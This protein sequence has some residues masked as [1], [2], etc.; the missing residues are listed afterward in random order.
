MDTLNETNSDQVNEI[1]DGNTV[2][3]S[4]SLFLTRAI[5]QYASAG[6][7]AENLSF[8]ATDTIASH[9][10]TT[11]SVIH[12]DAIDE[13]PPLLIKTLDPSIDSFSIHWLNLSAF[14]VPLFGGPDFNRRNSSL[15]GS[16]C[17]TFDLSKLGGPPSVLAMRSVTRSLSVHKIRG[18][19]GDFQSIVAGRSSCFKTAKYFAKYDAFNTTSPDAFETATPDALD[20]APPDAFDTAPPDAFETASPNAFDILSH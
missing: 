5:R 10:T 7:K 17:N 14:L 3:G 4:G 11:S 2:T 1:T 18:S 9:V 12:L 16:S 6:V 15:Q 8:L 13:Q 19:F 20:T